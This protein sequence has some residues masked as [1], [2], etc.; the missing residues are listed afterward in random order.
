[1]VNWQGQLHQHAVLVVVVEVVVVPEDME[2]VEDKPAQVNL[3]QTGGDQDRTHPVYVE[4]AYF[5]KNE[6]TAI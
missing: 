6:Q 1:M 5:I 4:F 2:V 3:Q